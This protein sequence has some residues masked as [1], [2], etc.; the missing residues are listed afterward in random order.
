M[1]H[2][3][4][5]L[6]IV[7]LLAIATTS[8]QSIGDFR[9]KLSDPL[10]N[11]ET[12]RTSSIETEHSQQAAVVVDAATAQAAV[13]TRF[14]GYR[15]GIYSDNGPDAHDSSLAAKT[16]FE[17][18]FPDINVYWVYDNP[19]FKVTAGDCLTEEEAVML[20]ARVRTLF[21]KAY[22]MRAT[23]TAE[24]IILPKPKEVTIEEKQTEGEEQT[25][26]GEEIT[27]T[28]EPTDDHQPT[29]EPSATKEQ[30]TNSSRHSLRNR[31]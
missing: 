1:R 5:I 29:E 24:N 22:V 15:L 16:T 2:I 17:S 8:A 13:G 26:G 10:Y 3:K 19:Y 11:I 7:A 18:N 31:Q 6:T 27:D 4:S 30:R 21:P 14:Q 25:E 28:G 9:A 23:M 20:L 12:E